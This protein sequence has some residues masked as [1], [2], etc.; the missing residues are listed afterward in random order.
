[1]PNYFY[2]DAN[3]RKQGP[4]N[5]QSLQVLITQKEILPNTP[6]ETESGHKGLAGQIPGLFPVGPPP[7]P[8]PPVG[9]SPFTAT[10]PTS[11]PPPPPKELFCTNCGKPIAAQ[12][13]ACMSCGAKPIGHKKFCR[14]CGV[15]MNSEQVVCI[16]CGAKI[17][18]GFSTVVENLSTTA[19]PKAR[20][21]AESVL[22][23]SNMEKVK[24]LPRPTIIAGIAVAAVM[25]L[26]CLSWLFSSGSGPSTLVGEWQVEDKNVEYREQARITLFK[27]GTGIADNHEQFTWK[28]D[29]GRFY[30][31]PPSDDTWRR[32]LKSWRYKISRTTLTLT[33]DSGERVI[34]KKK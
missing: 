6:L 34:Y 25:G 10:P 29:S 26:F 17:A 32:E 2:T 14:Q 7:V 9:P 31:V 8:V 18:T 13:T 30:I 12:T 27:D 19:I 5:D 4:I 1:M 15:G 21:M 22:S 11:A 3:G 16:R 28:V 24:N 23:S 33:D 20:Q